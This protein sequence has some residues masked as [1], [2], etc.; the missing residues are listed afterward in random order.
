MTRCSSEGNAAVTS[1]IVAYY[2]SHIILQLSSLYQKQ[3]EIF[4]AV[5]HV[6]LYK[7]ASV[8]AKRVQ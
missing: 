3:S 1:A 4:S 2:I 8:V 5:A 6:E 7:A